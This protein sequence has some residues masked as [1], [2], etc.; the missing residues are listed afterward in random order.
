MEDFSAGH[1]STSEAAELL[2]SLQ[3]AVVDKG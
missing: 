2:A 3:E 1:I